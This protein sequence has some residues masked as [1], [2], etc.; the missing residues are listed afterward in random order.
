MERITLTRQEDDEKRVCHNCIGDDF[1]SE[2]I[3]ASGSPL[4]CT[5]CACTKESINLYDLSDRVHGVI[6]EHFVRTP[7]EP[8]WI[9]DML[10]REGLID[11]WLP[12]GQQ[13]QNLIFD[14]ANVSEE[15]AEDVA[16]TLAGRYAY[17]AGKHGEENPYDS[18]AYYVER[19]ANDTEFRLSWESFCDEI[20][21]RERFFPQ[22]AEP[23]LGEIF[24]DLDGLATSNGTRV[25]RNVAPLDEDFSIW[26]AR[27]AQSDGE[28]VNILKS[29]DRR[30][31][32]PPSRYAEVGRMNPKGV[33]VFY[34]ALNPETCIAEIRP[35]V[36]AM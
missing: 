34:G 29:P 10:I 4:K 28:I 26:R 27:T 5:Y 11:I 6:E 17:E 7:S 1:L 14:V 18:E 16:E 30:L 9:D 12:D 2:E 19:S 24:E 23:V 21:Y 15:I 13:T 22:S 3:K 31:G 32:S 33:S 36:E 35:P 8:N 25:I 20:M